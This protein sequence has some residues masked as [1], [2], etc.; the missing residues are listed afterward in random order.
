M[1]FFLLEATGIYYVRDIF[2]KM[3]NPKRYKDRSIRSLHEEKLSQL[4]KFLPT[5]TTTAAYS[6]GNYDVIANRQKTREEM[7]RSAIREKI[8]DAAFEFEKGRYELLVGLCNAFLKNASRGDDFLIKIYFKEGFPVNWQDPET[9]ETALHIVAACKARDT[10]RVIINDKSCNFLLRDA[11][12]RLPSEMAYLYG[13][14]PAVARL[15]GNKERK[16]AE[17]QGVII[18]YRINKE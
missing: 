10:L 8:H 2:R 12:G 17:E 13:E 14:D 1:F 18:T 3:R 15:L 7:C 4:C 6:S 5:P 11:K 9:G 16:Q